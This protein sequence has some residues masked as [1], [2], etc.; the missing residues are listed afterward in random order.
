MFVFANK[1]DIFVSHSESKDK[2]FVG[3]KYTLGHFFP[4]EPSPS[5][6]GAGSQCTDF[7]QHTQQ[8]DGNP[9]RTSCAPYG[10]APCHR[11]RCTDVV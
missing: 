1:H 5:L 3:L 11:P 4:S 7:T 10:V 9:S 2:L 6:T 8:N